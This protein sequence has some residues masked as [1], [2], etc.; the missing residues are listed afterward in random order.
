VKI[1]GTLFG[2]DFAKVWKDL[3]VSRSYGLRRKFNGRDYDLSLEY[4]VG[5]P[6]GAYTSWAM[7]AL[8]HHLIIQ[9][10]AI[11][12]GYT[13]RFVSYA[14]LGDDMVIWNEKVAKVYLSIMKDLGLEI[15]LS[16]SIISPHGKGYEFA[17]K[18]FI[19]GQ[20]VSPIS[21]DE[22]SQAIVSAPSLYQ[23]VLKYRLPPHII[24]RLM[25]LGYKDTYKSMRWRWYKFYQLVPTSLN[26]YL[27]ILQK[28]Y[29]GSS[30][31]LLPLKLQ[32]SQ[33]KG[34]LLSEFNSLNKKLKKFT[35]EVMFKAY[36]GMSTFDILKGSK[37]DFFSVDMYTICIH[38]TVQKV[39]QIRKMIAG[40]RAPLK[41]SNMFMRKMI[42]VMERFNLTFAA[43]TLIRAIN[44]V[45]YLPMSFLLRQ[46]VS[47]T[48]FSKSEY[49]RMRK[50][51]RLY[52]FASI[53]D[54]L[55]P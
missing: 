4:S 2:P 15:N 14:V 1:F 37:M 16:K 53:K 6:M 41:S 47:S 23:F 44:E 25:G 51:F 31:D 33:L 7:L 26:S 8:T 12:A 29:G 18:V 38:D 52:K 20:D 24:S 45:Q 36:G 17:K 9:I 13:R 10:A 54:K 19:G 11:K 49:I 30:N 35:E 50:F 21:Y 55:L 40:A 43:S 46:T 32:S 42:P 22:Y 27:A 5:Q 34:F 3:L 48:R 39:N 28:M